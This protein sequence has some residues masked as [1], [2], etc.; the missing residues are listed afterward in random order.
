M[1]ANVYTSE[2]IKNM[3]RQAIRQGKREIDLILCAAK[4]VQK[5]VKAHLGQGGAVF[6]C[7][8]GNNGADGI[9]AACRLSEE[10]IRC[11]VIVLGEQDRM[12]AGAQ[13]YAQQYQRYAPIY[14][15]Q[16]I[17]PLRELLEHTVHVDIYVDA[18]L[19]TGSN[20]PLD[21]VYRY[22][23][24]FLTKRCEE[25]E[26]VLAI[27]VP[28]GVHPDTGGVIEVAVRARKT[29]SMQGY[30]P[31]LLVYPGADYAGE[32]EVCPIFETD[33]VPCRDC[34]LF[35]GEDVRP[36]GR[37]R[38]THKGTYGRVGVVAGSEGMAG[39]GILCAQA[40][41]RAGA[42]TVTIATPQPLLPVY[43]MT[44]PC[45]MTFALPVR[46]R[47]IGKCERQLE[48]FLKDK[49]SVVLG[50]GMGGNP[51]VYDAVQ[52]ALS[53]K[54]G[55][56]VVLDADALNA[57][58]R[59]GTQILTTAKARP[60]L[61]PHPFEMARLL[62]LDKEEVLLDPI[63]TALRCAEQFSC[64]AVLKGAST[65]ISDGVR[66]AIV[67]AGCAGM[68][69][70]GSGDVLSGVM[71]ALCSRYPDDLFYAAC[72]ACYL[73]GRAGEAAQARFGQNSMLPSDTVSCLCDIFRELEGRAG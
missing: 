60:V 54:E 72:L 21:G 35:D 45:A 48:Q 49:T 2:D 18:M 58:S 66:T 11:R 14:F 1:G 6:L 25:G 8:L 20:R 29:L 39:A 59:Q 27:D 12:S 33:Y 9:A 28:T 41:S 51:E 53:A 47:G 7:G 13:Y 64:I 55:L 70:G 37:A 50:P 36:I 42:G 34:I 10:G 26:Y 44:T 73:C 63:G 52:Y 57:L 67:T 38:N 69:K 4:A 19:G 68:A 31:G 24:E 62:K 46:G 65:V 56:P 32:V 30:K 5:E 22:A 16:D 15:L 17:D 23:A 71:A 43:A 3:D 61:T 40:A